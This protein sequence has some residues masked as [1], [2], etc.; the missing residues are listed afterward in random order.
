MDDVCADGY[1]AYA[2]K[3]G[4]HE[5]GIP[6]L[7][8]RAWYEAQYG[9]AGWEQLDRIPRPLWM[10]YLNWYRETLGLAV[11]SET[12]LT[13]LD[14][15][16]DELFI[17][18]LEHCGTTQTVLATGAEGSGDRV[19]PEFITRAV[20]PHLR[21]HSNDLIDFLGLRGKRIGVLG[22]G[23]SAFDNAATALEAGA[24]EAHLC[25]R[26]P[27]LPLANPRRW[28]ENA[29]FLAHYVSLYD[30]EKWAYMKRL[31]DISQPPPAP[32][33]RRATSLAGFRMHPAT[34][35]L[36]LRHTAH[37]T[38]VADTPSGEM[39]FD[40]VI[41]ATGMVVDLKRRPELA[42]IA[43]TVALWG[44]HYQPAPELAD[45]AWRAFPTSARIANSSRRM[46]AAHPGLRAS[47]P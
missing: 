34:P 40:F 17:L 45:S 33:L 8:F 18:T 47:S 43:D 22:A 46:P 24:A 10:A 4:G 28:M 6:S 5:L 37:D 16:G 35:W 21:A 26:R 11:Q 15:L 42:A 12:R 36:A 7:S 27:T 39:E 41:A 2:K 44:D 29:G 32:T 31:Y 14:P 19:I 9:C 1:A 20:P 30:A 3:C 23:T 38:V 25:Y 13:A